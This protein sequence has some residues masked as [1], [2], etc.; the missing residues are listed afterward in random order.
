MHRNSVFFRHL[1]ISGEKKRNRKAV[2]KLDSSLLNPR[3]IYNTLWYFTK[4]CTQL[5]IIAAFSAKL[6]IF[7]KYIFAFSRAKKYRF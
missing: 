1:W 6:G 7:S 5:Q 3:L 2:Q 4:I